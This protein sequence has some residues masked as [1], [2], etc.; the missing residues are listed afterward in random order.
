LSRKQLIILHTI[1]F[2]SLILIFWFGPYYSNYSIRRFEDWENPRIYPKTNLDLGSQQYQQLL[3]STPLDWNSIVEVKFTSTQ[4]IYILLIQDSLAPMFEKSVFDNGSG[5]LQ[6][7]VIEPANYTV[8]AKGFS[9][10]ANATVTLFP[11][12]VTREKPY[13]LWGQIMYYGG[14]VLLV[15]CGAFVVLAWLGTRQQLPKRSQKGASVIK[16]PEKK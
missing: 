10:T 13:A 8:V 1:F 3:P 12:I 4:P 5:E 11:S 9:G 15:A 16:K 6:Y 2:I 7:Y 14:I